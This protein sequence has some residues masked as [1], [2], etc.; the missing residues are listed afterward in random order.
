V[1]DG[2]LVVRATAEFFQDLD[3][4]LPAERGPNGERSTYDFQAFELLRIVERF[5]T[6]S[7]DLP[8]LIPGRPENRLLIGAGALVAG[9]AVVGQLRPTVRSSSC[10]STSMSAEPGPSSASRP[11]SI[12]DVSVRPV[13][14]RPSG[15]DVS[16]SM[17]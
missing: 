9:F 7:R 12:P 11:I 14:I 4:Q 3:R 15:V 5:A 2:R 10:G 1:S 8:E 16:Q 13:S 17:M 6:G